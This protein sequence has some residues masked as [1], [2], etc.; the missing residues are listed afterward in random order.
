M[1]NKQIFNSE[2]RVIIVLGMGGH[3]ADKQYNM[4]S[5]PTEQEIVYGLADMGFEIDRKE[6]SSTLKL[7]EE[8]G[9]IERLTRFSDGSYDC[10]GLTQTGLKDYDKK[11]KLF[12][13]DI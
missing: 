8:N 10:F 3:S 2:E 6:L 9:K 4:V 1:K 7:A 13:L 12:Y 5:L 11:N